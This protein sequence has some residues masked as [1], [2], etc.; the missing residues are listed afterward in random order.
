MQPVDELLTRSLPLVIAVFIATAMF[1]LGLG[2]KLDQIVAPLRDRR[3]MAVSLL[4]SVVVVPLI[5]LGLAGLI[6]MDN[7]LRTGFLVYAMAA[8]TPAGPKFVQLAK[9]NAA[10]AVGLL[11][12]LLVVTVVALPM[13][14]SVV[15]PDANVELGK[16]VPGLLLVAL[17]LGLGL[18]LRARREHTA[19]RLGQA[20]H[21][22]SV[23]LLLLVLAQVCY[24]HFPAVLA[25]E[26]GTLAAGLLFFPI[27]FAAGYA[28]GG[29][30][31]SNRR[32]L[33]IMTFGRN[34]SIALMIAS[35]VFAHDP[36]VMVM[37]LAMGLLS[38]TLA[39]SATAWLART[40]A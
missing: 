23:I 27:A 13:V 37:I 21:R 2:L 4:A 30:E 29:P 3:L 35:Q 17:P 1:S 5:A 33:A 14:V 32:A 31:R 6:P 15:V 28:M 10:F 25:L 16:I 8:G 39:T 26:A 38:L 7:S 12:P 11:A 9:G 24:V 34:G 36:K 19:T 18:Y 40:P 20:M 22:A